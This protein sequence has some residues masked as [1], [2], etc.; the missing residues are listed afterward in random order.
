MTSKREYTDY[1]CDILDAAGK[2]LEFV[3]GIE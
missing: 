1:L 3:G 2:A